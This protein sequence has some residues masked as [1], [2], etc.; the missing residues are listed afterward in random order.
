MYT[1][2]PLSH[3]LVARWTLLRDQIQSATHVGAIHVSYIFYYESARIVGAI[4][5]AWVIMLPAEPR[6]SSGYVSD[7]P[8][9]AGVHF[10]DRRARSLH[11]RHFRGVATSPAGSQ[12]FGM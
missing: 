9:W 4:L 1:L 2:L 3:A 6:V 7:G 12:P 5:H 8:R 11:C 10:A